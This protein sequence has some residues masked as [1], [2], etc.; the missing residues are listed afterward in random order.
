MLHPKIGHPER[1]ARVESGSL[2]ASHELVKTSV[3]KS[4]IDAC[5]CQ[6]LLGRDFP[7]KTLQDLSGHRSE[8]LAVPAPPEI[9]L[10]LA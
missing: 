5:A 6:A 2:H 4:V 1:K 8:A 7:S 9:S 10:D 3:A